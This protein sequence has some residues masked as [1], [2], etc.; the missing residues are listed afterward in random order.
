MTGELHAPLRGYNDAF[1]WSVCL[2]Y[3]PA[4]PYPTQLINRS[5]SIPHLHTLRFNLLQ[6]KGLIA[7]VNE[8]ASPESHDSVMNVRKARTGVN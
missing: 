1:N 3:Y 4:K 2:W 6:S 5:M 7:E 8:D